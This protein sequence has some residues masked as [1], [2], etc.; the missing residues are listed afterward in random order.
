MLERRALEPV[1]ERVGP[2]DPH[3]D[4]RRSQRRHR[5]AALGERA[6][7]A[8]VGTEPRPRRTAEREDRHIG[9]RPSVSCRRRPS[10]AGHRRSSPSSGS[11]ARSAPRARP[12]AT[13]TPGPA[14][15]R[16]T[17]AG[18]PARSTRRTSAPPARRTSRAGP[19]GRTPRASARAG[20]RSRRTGPGT[21]AILAVREV[22]PAVTGQ[23]ELARRRRHAV[24]HRHRDTGPG[25][26]LGGDQPGRTAADDARRAHRTARRSS[27]HRP[28]VTDVA[29]RA[30]VD[31]A[32]TVRVRQIR[33]VRVGRCGVIAT[34]CRRSNCTVSPACRPRSSAG[35]LFRLP[36]SSTSP[37][38]SPGPT[39]ARPGPS[40]ARRR[41]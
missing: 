1:G 10:G 5:H 36:S 11:A 20:R 16:G 17:T 2:A 37:T 28:N 12:A 22:Q 3:P 21:V 9:R 34:M 26:H 33:S 35:S 7:P 23:Q 40:P 19:P 31:L 24:V 6:D 41:A 29:G 25:E 18:T 27:R 39:C 4:V 13:A 38:A 8:A 14:V 15:S 30:E 32:G